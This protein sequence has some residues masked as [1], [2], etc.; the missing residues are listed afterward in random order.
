MSES[1]VPAEKQSVIS[2]LRYGFA[3]SARGVRLLVVTLHITD[4]DIGLPLPL[5]DLLERVFEYL[6]VVVEFVDGEYSQPHRRVVQKVL[7]NGQK[8]AESKGIVALR[9][10]DHTVPK[11]AQLNPAIVRP[12][13]DNCEAE[14]EDAEEDLRQF[15][16]FDSSG[17]VLAWL[18][19]NAVEAVVEGEVGGAGPDE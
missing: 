9:I 19:Q 3:C 7:D 10:Y 14:P 5:L 1:G 12:V 15:V 16:Y 6:G 2:V 11:P 18:L 13:I 17:G 4:L 8:R